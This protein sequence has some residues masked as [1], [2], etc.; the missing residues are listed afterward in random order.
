M[1]RVRE[2][3]FVEGEEWVVVLEKDGLDRPPLEEGQTLLAGM[4]SFTVRKVFENPFGV[5]LVGKGMVT[6]GLILRPEGELMTAAAYKAHA[7]LLVRLARAMRGVD[8]QGLVELHE[9][10]VASAF[11]GGDAMAKTA[12]AARA[13]IDLGATEEELTAAA[14]AFGIGD[15]L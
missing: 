1:Y 11:P 13:I 3:E 6:R 8:L 7:T 10:R 5:R 4:R 9:G 2:L 12:I 14:H 15:E